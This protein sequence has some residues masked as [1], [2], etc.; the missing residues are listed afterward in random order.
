MKV[1]QNATGSMNV[2]LI[3]LI[4]SV[5]FF[6]GA[7]GFGVWAYIGMQDYKNNTDQKI[8]AAV[9]VAN[10]KTS[11][12]KDNEFLVREKEPLRE[13]KSSSVLGDIVFNY[14]K[15]WSG[16]TQETDSTLK[17]LMNPGLVPGDAKSIYSLRVEVMPEAYSL[18]LKKYE[19]DVKTGKIKASAFRLEKLPKVLG[20]RLDGEISMGIRGSIILLPLRDK[21]LTISTE[22]EEFVGDLNTIV[23]PSFS[24]SP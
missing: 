10:D 23:L 19:N 3:P 11:T 4:L 16:Y 17:L 24:Y 14:P 6:F 20:T 13:Y 8:E 15:T 12:Q 5:L 18:A 21:T 22:S 9:A 7:L 1:I 2:L